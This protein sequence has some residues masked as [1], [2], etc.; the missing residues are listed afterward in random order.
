MSQSDQ[1]DTYKYMADMLFTTPTKRI[2]EVFYAGKH[3]LTLARPTFGG[4]PKGVH[5][6]D[7]AYVYDPVGY[8]NS[9]GNKS[10]WY[11]SDFTPCFTEDVPKE[12]HAWLLILT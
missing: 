12:L 10:H 2:Y 4:A 3:L 8:T 7:G 9:E 1:L 5:L 11:Y 6:P